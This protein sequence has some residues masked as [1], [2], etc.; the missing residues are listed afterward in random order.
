MFLPS[1]HTLWRP[2][3][4][5]CRGATHATFPRGELKPPKPHIQRQTVLCYTAR[6]KTLLCLPL[7]CFTASSPPQGDQG[8]TDRL[9]LLFLAILC[10]RWEKKLFFFWRQGKFNLKRLGTD[11]YT[12]K[13]RFKGP[14][15]QTKNYHNDNGMTTLLYPVKGISPSKTRISI[16]SSDNTNILLHRVIRHFL[17]MQTQLQTHIESEVK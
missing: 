3:K 16:G 8:G 5:K 13:E 6:Q 4:H 2:R 1:P 10:S 7:L 15:P 12:Q 9:S 14:P 11:W 17:D